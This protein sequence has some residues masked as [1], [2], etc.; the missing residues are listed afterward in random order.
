[1]TLS[2]KKWSAEEDKTRGLIVDGQYPAILDTLTLKM[3]KAGRFDTKGNPIPQQQ[4]LEIDLIVID[5]ANRE[6]KLKDWVLLN[7]DMSWKW[8]HVC[9]S[10]G[11]EDQYDNETIELKM[12]IGKQVIIDL[13][14]KKGQNQEG[15]EVMRNYV[16]DYLKPAT[17]IDDFR[18]DL[19]VGF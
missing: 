9:V 13:K 6:R 5:M 16:A 8:K 1:M 7:G 4:M 14:S 10:C 2:Y 17:A 18:D 15:V 19:S 11:L 12:L 3:T